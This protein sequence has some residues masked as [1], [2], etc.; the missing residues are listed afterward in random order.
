MAPANDAV[1]YRRN[2]QIQDAIDGQNLKQA[3]QLI[4][5]RM[6]KGEDTRFLKAWKAHVLFRHAD[7]AH[8]KRGIAETLELC[9][10]EPPTTDLDTLDM[11]HRTLQKMD[12]Q[13]QTR[14]NLWEKAAKAQPQGLEIQTRW[15]TY[16]YEGDDWKSAQKAAMSLQKNFPRERKYYFWAIFLCHLVANDSAS[17]DA[18]R[19][20]FGTL[21]YRMI[22]KAAADTPVEPVDTLSMPK[23]IKTAEE[24]LLLVKIFETQGLH[25]ELLKLLD[26]KNVGISSRI[27]QNDW[28]FVV[29]KISNLAAAKLW[30]DA[31]AYIKD[32]LTAPEPVDTER[33]LQKHDDWQ[34]W[35]VLIQ[36]VRNSKTPGLAAESL[37]F[38]EGFIQLN[39]KSRNGHLVRLELIQGRIDVG[40]MKQEDMLSACQSYFDGHKHKLYVFGDLRGFLSSANQTVASKMVEYVLNSKD[41]DEKTNHVYMI[42]ALKL[43][44][45]FNISGNESGVSK[46]QIEEFVVRCLELYETLSGSG[47]SEE[48]TKTEAGSAPATVESQPRDDLGILAAMS[49]L[50]GGPSAQTQ[51]SNTALIRAASILERLLDNSPHNYQALLLLVRVYLSLGAG[52]LALRTF[53]KLSVKQVQFETVAHNLF[54]RLATIHPHSA[55]PL[56]GAEFKDFDPQSAFVQALNFYRNT[57]ITTTKHRTNGLEYGSYV[58]TE[59]TI[60]L[61]RRLRDSVCRR[62]YVLDVRRMQRLVGGDPMSRYDDLAKDSSPVLDQ[63][64]FDAFMNCEAPGK[65]TFEER[66]RLGPL[67]GGKWLTSTQVTD[68]LFSLLKGISIQKP[69]PA[70]DELLAFKDLSLSDAEPEQTSTEKENAEIHSELLKVAAFMAGSK[71]L[72]AEQADGALGRVEEWLTS[73]KKDLTLSEAKVSPML[74]R[75]TIAVQS[76]TPAAPTWEYLHVVFH[77]LETV[78]ALSQLV[79]LASRKTV[80]TAKLPKERVER[81][82][83]L[84]SE[85]FESVRSNTRVLKLRVSASGLLSVLVGLV[86]EGDLSQGYGKDLRALLDKTLDVPALELFCGALM[87]SWEDALDG[88]MMVKL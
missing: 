50:Y 11:L 39:P 29:S 86:M 2:N 75:T 38:V 85:V 43:E 65:P 34:V 81:L 15:F 33:Y 66:M 76:G 10:A 42:N 77:L 24:M 80:K 84:V 32:L 54:T 51:I 40:D 35:E 8:H 30:E 48:T 31:F 17:S 52:S 59:D 55:P 47:K 82:S 74:A 53:S 37:K 68:R 36:A 69:L 45:C 23:S 62:M 56:E 25:S 4:E 63:R 57:A 70:D 22:S 27:V 20:L 78:K 19:K 16:S 5:K 44:Y 21:A 3:L 12:G 6:K 18:D 87:E 46:E 83:T 28:T 49:L 73:K 64:K 41:N 79:A 9:N 88:V 58:N 14:S 7:E 71:S 72:T 61:Q 60:E 1:F 26:S 13:A 67:P